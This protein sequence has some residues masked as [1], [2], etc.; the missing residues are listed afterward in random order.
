MINLE[1]IGGMIPTVLPLF[2]RKFTSS[3][4]VLVQ[5]IMATQQQEENQ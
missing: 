1:M 3:T 2:S 5:L 4:A